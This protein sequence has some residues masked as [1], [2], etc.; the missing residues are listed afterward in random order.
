MIVF[1][2]IFKRVIEDN[3]YGLLSQLSHDFRRCSKRHR[4]L[5]L[6]GHKDDF[7]YYYSRLVFCSSLRHIL[8]V[9]II[10][11]AL[12]SDSGVASPGVRGIWIP[13]FFGTVS[14]ISANPR[15]FCRG[16]LLC[17]IDNIIR[18]SSLIIN[19]KCHYFVG[20]KYSY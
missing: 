8:G 15:S 13:H 17:F 14:E 3:K 19:V 7:K 11:P 1:Q 2:F 5:K 4:L 16:G 9:Q 18:F 20:A 6:Q 12:S 10:H